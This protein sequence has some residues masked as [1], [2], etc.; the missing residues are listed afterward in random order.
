VHKLSFVSINSPS[1]YQ[2]TYV[3][4]KLHISPVI[5]HFQRP[6]KPWKWDRKRTL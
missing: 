5:K 4:Y 2:D 1:H 3:Q 6:W